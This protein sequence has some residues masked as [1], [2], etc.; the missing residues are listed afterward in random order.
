MIETTSCPGCS[1]RY[2]VIGRFALEH[3]KNMILFQSKPGLTCFFGNLL[4]F[5]KT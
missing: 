4:W 5:L 3:G 1:L 2:Y